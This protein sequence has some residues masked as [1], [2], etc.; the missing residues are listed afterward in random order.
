MGR[1]L[2]DLLFDTLLE[3][4]E[5]LNYYEKMKG[6]NDMKRHAYLAMAAVLLVGLMV[7]GRVTAAEPIVL[8]M[9]MPWPVQI[10]G[11]QGGRHW[12][13]ILNE[14]GKGKV[15]IKV[16]GGPEIASA[17]EL[18]NS[19]KSGNIDICY[20]AEGY[21]GGPMPEIQALSLIYTPISKIRDSGLWDYLDKQVMRKKHGLTILGGVQQAV[22]YYMY[23][24]DPVYKADLTGK[25]MRSNTVYD[26]LI[27]G[28]GGV[29]SVVKAEEVYTALERK[30]VDGICWSSVVSYREFNFHK[31]LRYKIGPGFMS[32]VVA[33]MMKAGKYDALPADVKDLMAQTL[34]ET[35]KWAWNWYDNFRL[36]ELKD[37]VAKG[38]ITLI[39]LS[40]EEEAKFLRVCFE[41]C[42]QNL[43]IRP[44]PE[45]GPKI[46]E[47]VRALKAQEV[48]VD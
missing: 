25:R 36:S 47:I 3:I 34:R 12:V 23:T 37:M 27:K 14:R 15:Q 21:L 45:H 48:K 22:P 26:P 38:Q 11:N 29:P 20:N 17:F 40:P 43:V 30:V 33:V 7:A 2:P 32:S 35:E 4:L 24:I 41:E 19:L 18:T 5:K 1:F 39:K 31:V 8:K 10:V 6:G 46:A 16:L 42:L 44:S 9:I 28:L 13:E